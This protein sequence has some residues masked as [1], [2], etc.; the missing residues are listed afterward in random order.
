MKNL[1]YVLCL[2]LVGCTMQPISASNQIIIDGRSYTFYPQH[3]DDYVHQMDRDIVLGS[4]VINNGYGLYCGGYEI[5]LYN[6]DQILKLLF[7]SDSDPFNTTYVHSSECGFYTRFHI[8][9]GDSNRLIFN[10]QGSNNNIRVSLINNILQVYGILENGYINLIIPD[11][12]F[13]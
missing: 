13:Y 2:F 5:R 8:Y 9:C 12:T 3:V 10:S 7:Y 4:Y 6:S 11:F 1:I